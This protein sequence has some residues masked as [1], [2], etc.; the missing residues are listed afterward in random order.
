MQT[1]MFV[2]ADTGVPAALGDAR[3]EVLAASR[4]QIRPGLAEHVA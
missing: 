4:R 3:G 2:L 1:P